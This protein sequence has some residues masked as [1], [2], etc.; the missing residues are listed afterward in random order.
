[1]MSFALFF[2]ASLANCAY[3]SRGTPGGK[4]PLATINLV[5][6]VLLPNNK[7][8]GGK[9]LSSHR[10]KHSNRISVALRN[11]AANL[12]K[13]N[14]EKNTPLHRFGMRLLHKKGKSAAVVAIAGKIARIIWR[15]LSRFFGTVRE[16]KPFKQQS[17]A[18]YEAYV[19]TQTVKKMQQQITKLNISAEE[20]S[21]IV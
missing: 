10:I 5:L 3:I 7:I 9:V 16:Q 1:M 19:R 2:F 15:Y 18:D 8:S 13:A 20:L 4:L 11:G 6:G 12:I 21:I 14:V 17:L